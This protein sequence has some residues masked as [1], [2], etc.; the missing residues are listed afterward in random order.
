MYLVLDTDDDDRG[1]LPT[2]DG[3]IKVPSETMSRMNVSQLS[4]LGP[5][6]KVIRP[7]DPSDD[8]RFVPYSL[9]KSTSSP[10][11]SFI[12]TVTLTLNI[13]EEVGTFDQA[14][15]T[16]T[17]NI[18]NLSAV[19]KD[20]LRNQRYEQFVL[21][22][23][24]DDE[25]S[26]TTTTEKKRNIFEAWKM[27]IPAKKGELEQM[28]S[29][30]DVRD[31]INEQLN[32]I[33]VSIENMFNLGEGKHGG[34]NM[35]ATDDHISDLIRYYAKHLADY[36]FDDQMITNGGDGEHWKPF[37]ALFL[38]MYDEFH[39]KF[40]KSFSTITTLSKT[41]NLN[42]KYEMKCKANKSFKSLVDEYAKIFDMLGRWCQTIVSC[43]P[44]MWRIG[45]S[46]LQ[47]HSTD[48]GAH[49][50]DDHPF[51]TTQDVLSYSPTINALK[52]CEEKIKAFAIE[53][54]DLCEKFSKTM[55]SSS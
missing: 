26:T 49:E 41:I 42:A 16:A 46:I 54:I 38:P 14:V 28:F 19:L 33:R 12:R 32:T 35:F 47:E 2:L 23:E 40:L 29:L 6:V 50:R 8:D 27:L 22:N 52:E 10:D 13:P 1:I 11:D 43:Y 24:N 36:T 37:L 9:V 34:T 25:S 5:I 44:E 21:S 45:C 18:S 4:Q 17:F 15:Q 31:H 51:K 20:C 48:I 53:G 39:G 3:L 30:F 7:I 55:T